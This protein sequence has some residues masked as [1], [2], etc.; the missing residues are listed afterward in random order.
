MIEKNN[1]LIEFF[2]KLASLKYNLL[3]AK[4]QVIAKKLKDVIES[5]NTGLN[6]RKNFKLGYGGNYYVTIKNFETGKLILDDKC[7]KIDNDA[8][9]KINKRSKIKKGDIL[10]SSI[11][12]I[13]SIYLINEPP[14]NWNISESVFSIRCNSK[15]S[16][17]I[18]YEIL[19]Y[20]DVQNYCINNASG[21]AQKGIR[22]SSLLE[23]P[24]FV[25]N[26]NVLNK[27]NKEICLIFKEICLIENKQKLLLNKKRLLLNKYFDTK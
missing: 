21:S 2:Y 8:I 3:V 1:V 20:K 15:I 27:F 25:P 11:G 9:T 5:I 7:D 19:Y 18:L 24:V 23:C 10:F 26:P 14:K 4:E 6:P 16:P 12:R 13:G 17:E 22:I